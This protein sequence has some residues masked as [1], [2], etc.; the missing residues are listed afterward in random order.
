[1]SVDIQWERFSATLSCNASESKGCDMADLEVLLKK[2]RVLVVTL[3]IHYQEQTH[4]STFVSGN[5]WQFSDN[6]E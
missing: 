3:S 4:Q 2:K 1:V 6:G 5:Q